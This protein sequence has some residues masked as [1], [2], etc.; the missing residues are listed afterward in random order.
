LLS[1]VLF[2]PWYGWVPEAD[3]RLLILVILKV[4]QR[5]NRFFTGKRTNWGCWMQFDNWVWKLS[6]ESILSISKYYWISSFLVKQF[7]V[8]KNAQTSGIPKKLDII[9]INSTSGHRIVMNYLQYNLKTN[10]NTFLKF[11]TTN[12]EIIHLKPLKMHTKFYEYALVMM[13]KVC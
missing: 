3:H 1:K 5:K 12:H 6:L 4:Y 11:P 7:L 2:Y 13:K 9:S 8:S 10:K